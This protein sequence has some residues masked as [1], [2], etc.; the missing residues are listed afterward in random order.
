MLSQSKQNDSFPLGQFLIDGFHT[1]FSFNPGKNG[2]GDNFVYPGVH[3][4]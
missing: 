1:P 4:S 2:A 3:F